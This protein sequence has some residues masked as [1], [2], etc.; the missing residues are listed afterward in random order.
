MRLTVISHSSVIDT[1]QQ[2]FA[3]MERQGVV[4]QLL[5]PSVWKGD[6]T[7]RPMAPQ[8]WEGLQT[9]PIPIPVVMPGQV[10]LHAYKEAL[11]RRFYLFQPDAIYVEN[12]SYAV[13][14]FQA[15]L[16]NRMSVKRP[17]LFRNNQ[18]LFKRYPFPFDAAERYV[19]KHAACANVVNEEAGSVL[20]AKG[21][22]G[23][24]AY[25]PYGV[26]V[27][28]YHPMDARP[29]RQS[30]GLKGMVFGYLGRLVEEKGILKLI[31]AF[32][33]F[34]PEED[35]S[36]LVIGDGPLRGEVEARFQTPNLVGRTRYLPV[37]PHREVPLHLSAMD[38][39]VLPSETRERWKEQ[40]G[41]VLI[42]A[43]ACGVPV[44]GSNSGEIPH[45]IER[46][47]SGLIVPEG[48]VTALH[49]AMRRMVET[50]G[51][52]DGFRERGRLEVEDQ[53]AYTALAYRFRQLLDSVVY[54]RLRGRA[55]EDKLPAWVDE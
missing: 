3:E 24:I 6:L 10:P 12:E 40:F 21:Y 38:V 11:G 55:Q 31:E 30:L 47:H 22:K 49:A 2:L 36:L 18:N 28:F 34:H 13:S 1:N 9:T 4:L 52:H 27:N 7:G 37:V 54:D 25:M 39:L 43:P 33:R 53:Y 20:R 8:R 17:L 15:A 42:E 23:R 51:L 14:T 19:L 46:L 41:R 5:V 44:I 48:D 45:L 16:A 32:S 29:L 35:V 50:P 26:D